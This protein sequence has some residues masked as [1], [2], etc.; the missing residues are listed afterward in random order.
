MSFCYHGWMAGLRPM[1]SC[2]RAIMPLCH[3]VTM[4]SCWA[5]EECEPSRIYI[6][7]TWCHCVVMSPCHHVI[8]LSRL[9]SWFAPMCTIA[10]EMHL[11]QF[12][13][14][15]LCCGHPPKICIGFRKS[16]FRN[17]HHHHVIMSFMPSCHH[18]I[19]SSCWAHAECEPSRIYIGRTWCH[20]AIMSACH[21]VIMWSR[22]MEMH[23]NQIWMPIFCCEHEFWICIGFRKFIIRNQHHH[24][25]HLEGPVWAPYVSN[26][27]WNAFWYFV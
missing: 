17:Q 16:S 19:M 1:W 14:A 18:A 7:R 27:V 22:S 15:I 26:F 20:C 24:Q 4:P 10:I 11:N 23:F 13:I 9:G 5:H 25:S 2:H 3:H 21:H 6:E 8:M 12:L